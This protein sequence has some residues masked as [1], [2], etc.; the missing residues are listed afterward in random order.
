MRPSS[1]PARCAPSNFIDLREYLD[2]IG[3]TDLV[4]TMVADTQRL[5]LHH[6]A[7]NA[8]HQPLS[9]HALASYHCLTQAGYAQRVIAHPQPYGASSDL[10]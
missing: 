1:C 8:I 4:I 10:A 9:E 3:D 6:A 2:Q 7:G 5:T